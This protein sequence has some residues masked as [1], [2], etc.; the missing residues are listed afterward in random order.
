MGWKPSGQSIV[1]PH[2]TKEARVVDLLSEDA[3]EP[4]ASMKT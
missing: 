3:P 1:R 2:S 4:P